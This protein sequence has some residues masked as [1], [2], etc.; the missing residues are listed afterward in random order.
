MPMFDFKCGDC[1]HE[2]EKLAKASDQQVECPKCG[3]R[4]SKQL[5][6]PGDFVCKGGGFYKAGANFKTGGTSK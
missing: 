2:Q 5:S 4:M 1:G 3:G 6:A